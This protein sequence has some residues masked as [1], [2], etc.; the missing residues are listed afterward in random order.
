MHGARAAG[1]QHARPDRALLDIEGV[2]ERVPRCRAGCSWTWRGNEDRA[3][4]AESKAG[5]ARQEAGAAGQQGK[6]DGDRR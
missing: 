2:G 1:G 3:E 5:E 6:D 4:A